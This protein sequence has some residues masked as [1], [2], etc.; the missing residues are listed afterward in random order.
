[1]EKN[2]DYKMLYEYEKTKKFGL[3]AKLSNLMEARYS[4]IN[5]NKKLKKEINLI[6]TKMEKI[7]IADKINKNLN[8]IC[9]GFNITPRKFLNTIEKFK[10]IF[11]DYN[12]LDY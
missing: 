3:K 2:K 8:N 11:D 4:Y 7:K 6:K 5:E 9:K 12:S 10:N 1:M